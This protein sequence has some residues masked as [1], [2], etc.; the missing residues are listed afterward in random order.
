MTSRGSSLCLQWEHSCVVWPPGYS[1]FA[2]LLPSWE[3][4]Q[5]LED[6]GFHSC[7]YSKWSLCWVTIAFMSKTVFQVSPALSKGE[8]HLRLSFIPKGISIKKKI[9][10]LRPKFIFIIGNG[11]KKK[12]FYAKQVNWECSYDSRPLGS[13]SGW[14]GR[15]M[16][17]WSGFM[18]LLFEQY[19][20]SL[21]SQEENINSNLMLSESNSTCRSLVCILT[22]NHMQFLKPCYWIS[23]PTK[24][25]RPS[26][27][28]PCPT[29]SS[30]F[31]SWVLIHKSDAVEIHSQ[32]SH[33][34]SVV[35][36]PN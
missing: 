4:T 6:A 30:F 5:L 17:A 19:P 8:K 31:G 10:L 9:F 29:P 35:K 28:S 21:L 7:F 11:K 23:A 20:C 24:G 25:F 36:G 18:C 34:G 26:P 27:V 13:A 32:S 33:R 1:L 3:S 15:G 14:M 16:A 2:S 22:L 12:S